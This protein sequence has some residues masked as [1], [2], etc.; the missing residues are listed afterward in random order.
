MPI[1]TN[2]EYRRSRGTD[3]P[4]AT[5]P[6]EAN[7]IYRELNKDAIAEAR[8]ARKA[9]EDYR[10]TFKKMETEEKSED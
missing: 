4:F 8:A 10:A 2:E 3:H 9:V 7:A 5:T 6:D 1:M